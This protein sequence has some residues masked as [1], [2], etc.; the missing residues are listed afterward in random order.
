MDVYMRTDHQKGRSDIPTCDP[1]PFQ[2]HPVSDT[3]L[4]LCLP[5]LH[6]PELLDVVLPL[7]E[8]LRVQLCAYLPCR[9]EFPQDSLNLPQIWHVQQTAGAPPLQN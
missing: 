7:L 3:C 4:N 9:F 1:H 6:S 5:S 8:H 2:A